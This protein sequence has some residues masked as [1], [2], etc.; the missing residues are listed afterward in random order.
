MR[1]LVIGAL[2][3]A[4][5]G[6]M[7]YL[8]S[9]RPIA[10]DTARVTA[11][12]I[13]ET[14]QDE[15]VTRVRDAYVV[16]APVSGRLERIDLDVG[17][18]VL[19]GRTVVARLRPT[20]P[21][22]LDPRNRAQAVAAVAAADAAVAATRATRARLAAEAQR[23]ERA[24]KRII[25]LSEI[26]AASRQARD[27]AEAAAQASRAAV[28]ASDAEL[29]ARQAE[30]LS[31]RA[32][33]LGPETVAPEAVSVVAPATGYIT[34]VLQE[35]ERVVS[36]GAPLVE[37]SEGQGLEAQIEFLSQ[38]AVRIREGMPA[39]I[40][41]WGGPGSIPAV[42]RRVEPE[43][44]VKVSALGVEEHRVLVMLQFT[45]SADQWARMGP[46]YSVWGRVFLRREIRALKL[47]LGALVGSGDGWAVFRVDSGRARL[48]HVAVG[49]MTDREAEIRG[50]L[51]SGDQVVLF[52]SDR[53]R[54]GGLVEPR[55]PFR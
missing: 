15:G 41:D 49:A 22:L 55:R 47:P 50:G 35:S 34:R 19:A 13:S 11:G 32:A 42:V 20:P 39:E 53:V 14:V 17:D 8:F 27:D 10:V 45:G 29:A 26:G 33:L 28:E 38:D 5:I 52:P 36:T 40:Y 18:R 48:V 2:A 24:Y 30:A 6:V 16:S 46:G 31:A 44:F 4:A 1:W 9:P 51:K 23:A 43:G 37:I 54:D 3:A 21:Q 25:P 12:P 7:V